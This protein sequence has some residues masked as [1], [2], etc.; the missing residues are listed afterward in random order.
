MKPPD[1]VA[2]DVVEEQLGGSQKFHT[3]DLTYLG[4]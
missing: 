2:V 3:T 4:F 1:D